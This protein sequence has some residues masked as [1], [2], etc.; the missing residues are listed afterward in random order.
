MCE[1]SS[2][3]NASKNAAL[4]TQSGHQSERPIV[5]GILLALDLATEAELLVTVSSAWL[6]FCRADRLAVS[7]IR[8][9]ET[10]SSSKSVRFIVD[11]E[12]QFEPRKSCSFWL[13]PNVS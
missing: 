7:G 1:K 11:K 9:M 4:I 8:V 6:S 13:F 3:A 12:A 10:A 2:R 5:L